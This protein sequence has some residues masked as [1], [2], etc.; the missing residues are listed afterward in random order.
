[1]NIEDT[2]SNKSID[3]RNQILQ[4]ALERFAKYGY[5]QTKISDIVAEAGVAQ[6]TFYWHFK[7]KE[8]IAL[9]IIRDGQEQ[10]TAVISRGYRERVGTI[11]DMVQ[12]SENLLRNLFKFAED[13]RYLMELLL[14]GNG[15]D[16]SIRSSI[17]DTR[18][19]MEVSFR[20]NIERA[21]ELGML[22]EG[23]DPELRAAMLM[24]LIEGV[25]SRWLLNKADPNSAVSNR[26]AEELAAETARFEFFGLLGI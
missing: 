19:A 24:S 26:S 17:H 9:E 22:P 13:H 10:L 21:I 25:L 11:Q 12:A 18:L 5:H 15:V 6:G 8:A 23:I 3:R 20:R 16:E 14:T 2:N 7:S 1:M 4:I